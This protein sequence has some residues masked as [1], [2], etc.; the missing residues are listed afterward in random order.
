MPKESGKVKRV[1][2]TA[3]VTA[4]PAPVAITPRP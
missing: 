4:R 1:A 2:R 3:A